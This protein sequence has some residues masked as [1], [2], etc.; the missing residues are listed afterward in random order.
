[1]QRKRSNGRQLKPKTE[2][3]DLDAETST[4]TNKTTI[5]SRMDKIYRGTAKL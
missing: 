4:P 3:Q 1:M 5:K 2:N